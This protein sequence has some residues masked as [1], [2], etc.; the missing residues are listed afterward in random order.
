[1][2]GS[3]MTI[4][5]A[6]N[7]TTERPAPD[8]PRGI[9]V[10][11]STLWV[12]GTSGHAR[13][14]RTIARACDPIARRWREIRLVDRDEEGQPAREG[15]ALVLGMGKPGIRS[16]VVQRWVG[17]T[18][19]E[20]PTLV[21][22]TAVVGP[23]VALGAGVVV[24]PGAVLTCDVR[25]G[26]WSMVNTAAVVSHDAWIGSCC[27]VNP[28]AT[29]SGG[30]ALGDRAM[31]GAGAVVLEG[32]RVGRDAVVGAGAVV[33]RDVPPGTTVVGVPARAVGSSR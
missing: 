7:T 30:V 31:V 32:R 11:H 4:D 14:M 10:R 15:G 19:V 29:I 26:D 5:D 12:L 6:V 8:D 25:I 16:S 21:H 23:D 1:M 18:G 3:D 17:T 27:L 13:E 22:P 9:A 24:A 33:T 2:P 20:W 28:R